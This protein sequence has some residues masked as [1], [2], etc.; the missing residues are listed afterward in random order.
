M[1]FVQKVLH[2]MFAH[3]H[4]LVVALIVEAGKGP[5]VLLL[6]IVAAVALLM[7][8]Q[9]AFGHVEVE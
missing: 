8:A 5:A 6:L 1:H 7:A 2:R 9:V 4:E 3:S